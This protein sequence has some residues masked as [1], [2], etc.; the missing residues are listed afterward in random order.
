[1]R[2]RL[3]VCRDREACLRKLRSEASSTQST[4]GSESVGVVW[5]RAEERGGGCGGGL[6]VVGQK[7]EA[8]S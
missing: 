5:D 6:G 8:R 1:M 7:W 2:L 4:Q 3:S